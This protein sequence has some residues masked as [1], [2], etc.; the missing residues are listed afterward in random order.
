MENP[1]RCC[2]YGVRRQP[3]GVLWGRRVVALFITAAWAAGEMSA[4]AILVHTFSTAALPPPTQGT[5]APSTGTP[6]SWSIFVAIAYISRRYTRYPRSLVK[7]TSPERTNASRSPS[8]VSAGRSTKKPISPR[9]MPKRPA[10]PR[11]SIRALMGRERLHSSPISSYQPIRK[12]K[13]FRIY[14]W[15]D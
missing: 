10:Q 9:C 14:P 3:H 13:H 7:E 4:T 1:C 12:M 6:V 11:R 15:V 2:V 5:P 8:N